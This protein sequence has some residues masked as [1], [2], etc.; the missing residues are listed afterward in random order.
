[1]KKLLVAI[2]LLISTPC[3]AQTPVFCP[4]RPTTDHSNACASTQYVQNAFAGGAIVDLV[5]SGTITQTGTTFSLG[6]GALQGTPAGNGALIFK[7]FGAYKDNTATFWNTTFNGSQCGNASAR[8]LDASGLEQAAIYYNRYVALCGGNNA[9]QGILSIGIGSISGSLGNL[10]KPT[11]F[12]ITVANN[13]FTTVNPNKQYGILDIRTDTN[14]VFWRDVNNAAAFTL[15]LDNRVFDIGGVQN[16]F[17][18]SGGAVGVGM[19]LAATGTDPNVPIIIQPK[20]DVVIF[21]AAAMWT[22][23]GAVATGMTNV[24]PV[25]SHTTV[26]EWFTV[27]NN[28]GVVRYIPTF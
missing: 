11:W 27:K 18:I 19:T 21:N 28:A 5:V 7:A 23:N 14:T 2:L 20:A 26:Q 17:E 15:G 6:G 13:A 4:T 10:Q 22:A 24:G 12:G 1:M 16:Y 3:W 8:F 9:N 25:G